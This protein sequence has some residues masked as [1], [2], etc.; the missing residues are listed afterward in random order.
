M[1]FFLS[2][3]EL[4]RPR[5][6]QTVLYRDR[7][8]EIYAMW[9]SIFTWW[10][11]FN[12]QLLKLLGSGG[13]TDNGNQE[14][15]KD[16]LRSFCSRSFSHLWSCLGVPFNSVKWLPFNSVKWWLML[17]EYLKQRTRHSQGTH[18]LVVPVML[19]RKLK[20]QQVW[21]RG[22]LRL[23]PKSLLFEPVCPLY[24]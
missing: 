16:Q 3:R 13:I 24:L 20:R 12:F 15:I 17:A 10:S 22:K 14:A 1:Y 6:S 21:R 4:H 5:S 7:R 19:S 8:E 11:K 23:T 2:N 18:G 9:H